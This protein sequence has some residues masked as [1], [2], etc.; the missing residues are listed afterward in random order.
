MW[1]YPFNNQVRCNYSWLTDEKSVAQ[2]TKVPIY[3]QLII[4]ITMVKVQYA[5]LRSPCTPCLS[6]THPLCLQV[7]ALCF[8]ALWLYLR[9][10]IDNWVSVWTL[11][12][13]GLSQNPRSKCVAWGKGLNFSSLPS[14]VKWEKIYSTTL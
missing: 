13:D 4:K 14:S 12:S 1:P 11:D 3:I 10:R 6:A 5:V 2:K 7:L 8:L 9:R